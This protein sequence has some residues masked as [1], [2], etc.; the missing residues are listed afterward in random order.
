MKFN[1][2]IIKLVL[3]WLDIELK[4]KLSKEYKMDYENSLDLRK[5]I[6]SKK[7]SNSE[8]KKY[9]QVFSEK[10]GFLNDLSIIDLIFN[11]GPNSLSY[12][13]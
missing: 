13:K 11:E 6:D 8:N 7:K 10:N 9:K 1:F 3:E 5:K 12:L 4:S 2:D